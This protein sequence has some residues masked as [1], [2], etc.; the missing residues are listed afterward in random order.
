MSSDCSY[1]R[2]SQREIYYTLEFDLVDHYTGAPALRHI[3]D[4][5]NEAMVQFT[6]YLLI[7]G[8]ISYSL[9]ESTNMK[10]N[11]TLTNTPG[12]LP[13]PYSP[14]HLTILHQLVR[15]YWLNV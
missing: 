14:Y 6:R 12:L 9:H 4:N 5:P 3:L 1:D 15:L 13:P 11:Q 2:F 8:F 10:W 7:I